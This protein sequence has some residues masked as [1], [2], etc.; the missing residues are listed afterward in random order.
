[1]TVG[2]RL[3]VDICKASGGCEG[4][5]KRRNDGSILLWIHIGLGGGDVPCPGIQPGKGVI[6]RGGLSSFVPQVRVSVF[7][8]AMVS[9]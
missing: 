5:E 1:M 6:A 7:E 9:S 4:N 3:G 8:F 2:A